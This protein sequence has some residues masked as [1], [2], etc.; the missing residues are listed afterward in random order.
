MRSDILGKSIMASSSEPRTRLFAVVAVILSNFLE[1]YN[2]FILVSMSSYWVSFFARTSHPAAQVIGWTIFGVTYLARPLGSLV[3]GPVTDRGGRKVGLLTSL[4]ISSLCT[5][6]LG[7]LPRAETIGI[8]APISA[9]AVR[10][11]QGM[12]ID[13]A[14]AAA[15]SYLYE[16]APPARRGFLVSFELAGNMFALVSAIVLTDLFAPAAQA[17]AGAAPPQSQ[18]LLVAGAIATPLVIGMAFLLPD[19]HPYRTRVNRP[20]VGRII[21]A[22]LADWRAVGL[23]AVASGFFFVMLFLLNIVWPNIGR[24]S[25]ENAR[26]FHEISLA[27]AAGMALLSG[28]LS[29]LFPRRLLLLGT[30]ALALVTVVPLIIWSGIYSSYALIWLG[31]IIGA[32]GGTLRVVLAELMPIEVRATGIAVALTASALLFGGLSNFVFGVFVRPSGTIFRPVG[33]LVLTVGWLVIVGLLGLA[34]ARRIGD[35]RFV[36]AGKKA[37]TAE[38]AGIS[39]RRMTAKPQEDTNWRDHLLASLSDTGVKRAASGRFL[40]QRIGWAVLAVLLLAIS[41]FVGR[42]I[43]PEATRRDPEA[44]F[45]L[46]ILWLMFSI[47][48]LARPTIAALKRS[49]RAGARRAEAELKRSGSRRPILYLRS[50]NIDEFIGRTSIVEL[51]TG[52]GHAN[53]EQSL[54]NRLRRYGPVVAIGRPEEK[55]PALGA[56]RFY[57]S[58]DLWKAKVADVARAAQLVVWATGTTE[59]L[60]WEISHLLEQLPPEQLIVWAHPH[61]LRLLPADRE[62]AWQQFLEA[63]GDLFPYPLPPYLGITRFFHFDR[64]YRPIPEPSLRA[65]LQAKG[66]R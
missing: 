34:A 14:P 20:G 23:A 29:D 10:L 32:Y 55:L 45:F 50:F 2:V 61:L 57:V 43:I 59:G 7:L 54:V 44:A 46:S 39:P 41:A 38:N 42:V 4:A 8:I 16:S 12:T 5:L 52:R 21:L 26:S 22:V 17:G 62:I 60:R 64:D 33:V 24:F 56:A 51:L 58:H 15:I 66:I 25:G 65:V 63:L 37:R 48:V 47:F 3:L 28:W 13:G 30:I 18:M 6:A 11:I 40:G 9:I 31:A 35:W 49:W 27:V 19:P 53:A 1:F 36:E